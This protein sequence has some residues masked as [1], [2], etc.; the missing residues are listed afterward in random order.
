M[1][2][3]DKFWLGVI[4]AIGGFG[5]TLILVILAGAAIVLIW[6]MRNYALNAFANMVVEAHIR[7][8]HPSRDGNPEKRAT[9]FLA[10]LMF[11]FARRTKRPDDDNL[12]QD[13][14]VDFEDEYK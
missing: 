10:W 7:A 8:F 1:N 6:W 3:F 12:F 2:V 11:E 4:D 5:L 13:P 14:G 9:K